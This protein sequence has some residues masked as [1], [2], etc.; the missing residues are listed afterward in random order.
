MTLS[1][2]DQRLDV[3]G[4]LEQLKEIHSL[5]KGNNDVRNRI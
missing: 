3:D 4:A 1:D 2:V 5:Y